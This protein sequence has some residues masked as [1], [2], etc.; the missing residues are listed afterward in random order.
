MTSLTNKIKPNNFFSVQTS[1]LP[2]S[3][4]GLNSSVAQSPGELWSCYKTL[5]TVILPE[6]ASSE[7]IKRTNIHY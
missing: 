5:E 6:T 1:R 4:E 2:E 7:G 3:F